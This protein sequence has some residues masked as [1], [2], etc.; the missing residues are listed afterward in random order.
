MSCDV[1]KATEGL[2]NELWGRWSDGKVGEWVQ[3]ILKHF[4]HFTY[5]TAHF[6]NPSFAFPTSQLIL[7]PFRSFSNISVTSPTSQLFLH[8]QPFRH[9]T[10]VSA[11]SPILPFLHLHHSSFFNPCFAFPTSQSLRAAH[12]QMTDVNFKYNGFQNEWPDFKHSFENIDETLIAPLLAIPTLKIAEHRMHFA[13]W[14]IL[15]RFCR[16]YRV[17]RNY[18]HKISG[19]KNVKN[20]IFQG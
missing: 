5:V 10:Y 19:Y 20:K 11:H 13:V 16:T 8:L 2:E 4:R 9:F 12:D 3:L 17:R 18:V 15:S 14:S 1:G 7:Q 6:S